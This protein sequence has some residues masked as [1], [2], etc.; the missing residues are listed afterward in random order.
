MCLSTYAASASCG[1]R[2]HTPP[3][4]TRFF[5]RTQGTYSSTCYYFG[6]SLSDELAAASEDGQAPPIG[7]VHTSFGG[8]TIE[9]W[10][11]NATI[12]KCEGA[13]LSPQ[14]QEWHNQRVM[15]YV[16]MTV[17]GWVWYQGEND[18]HG[19]FG[20]S[21]LNSGYGCM[22]QNLVAQW[23]QLWSTEE[24]T[25]DPNAP[26]GLVTLAPSGTEGGKS[27]G[28]MRYVRMYV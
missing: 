6:E 10:L 16:D 3:N 13:T 2:P 19:Y 21:A 24:G 1:N 8:S 7:L 11:D 27:I 18:M 22:M 4:L 23:R 12:A 20:N 17:K 9:Q 14:N 15:P 28:T 26:F 5:A 25:T